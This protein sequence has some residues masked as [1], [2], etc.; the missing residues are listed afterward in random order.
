MFR[1]LKEQAAVFAQIQRSRHLEVFER[2]RR[3][4]LISP[5]VV[6][7]QYVAAP[8]PRPVLVRG[9]EENVGGQ[10]SAGVAVR[11]DGTALPGVIPLHRKNDLLVRFQIQHT[12]QERFILFALQFGDKRLPRLRH[13]HAFPIM[14]QTAIVRSLS[15]APF[16]THHALEIRHVGK[17]RAQAVPALRSQRVLH[18]RPG[19][20]FL[21]PEG[22]GRNMVDTIQIEIIHSS[23]PAGSQTNRGSRPKRASNCFRLGGCSPDALKLRQAV[24]HSAVSA[25]RSVLDALTESASAIN[26]Y[27]PL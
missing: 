23:S 16:H 27:Y 3:M 7:N 11:R 19:I 6:Q 24:N 13:V 15:V 12:A 8:F 20:R 26:N 17:R 14:Q 1:A 10:L 5:L 21:R 25:S 2:G 22:A 4:G 9:E 18:V